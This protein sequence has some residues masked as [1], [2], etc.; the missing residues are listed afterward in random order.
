MS[1]DLTSNLRKELISAYSKQ[2]KRK[3]SAGFYHNDAYKLQSFFEIHYSVTIQKTGDLETFYVCR[4]KNDFKDFVVYILESM[5]KTG[6]YSVG[7]PKKNVEDYQEVIVI[8]FE[9]KEG[10]ED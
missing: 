10:K 5:D 3:K 2:P 7:E 6:F 1:N 4:P 8:D 9:M